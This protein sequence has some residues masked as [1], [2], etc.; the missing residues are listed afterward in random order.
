MKSCE[1][2]GIF[3]EEKRLWQKFCTRQCGKRVR[4]VRYWVRRVAKGGEYVI[5]GA[6]MVR[7]NHNVFKREG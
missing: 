3:Y 1:G 4:N 7:G 5:Q 6:G 2:C